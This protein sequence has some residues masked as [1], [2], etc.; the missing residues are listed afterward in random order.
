M[1]AAVMNDMAG[2]VANTVAGYLAQSGP[3]EVNQAGS[4]LAVDWVKNILKKELRI[5]C[6]NVVIRL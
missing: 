2:L 5:P 3:L 6:I 1:V 4:R